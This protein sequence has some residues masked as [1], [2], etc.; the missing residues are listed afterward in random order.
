VL[1]IKRILSGAGSCP[2]LHRH[3]FHS[4]NN[5]K[6]KSV[7]YVMNRITSRDNL[8]LKHA[9]RVRDGMADDE[10]FIEGIRLVEE[11]LRSG[12][13]IND[14]FVSLELAAVERGMDLVDRLS[15][16]GISVSLVEHKLFQSLADTTNPQG[17]VL[18]CGRPD[19]SLSAFVERSCPGAI[20]LMVFLNEINNPSN[21]GAILRTAEAAGVSLV[22]ISKNSADAYSP[23]ALR[24]SMGASLR[25]NIWENA[26][27]NEAIGWAREKGVA[28]TAADVNAAK[29]YTEIDWT[30]PRL[31]VMG[32][33]AHGL[34]ASEISFIDEQIR[35]PMENNVESLNLAVSCGIIL[36]EAKRQTESS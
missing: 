33:E 30:I 16:Q 5:V 29:G 24:A 10:I 8:K 32:S 6:S 14:A 36:Y 13:Q 28:V 19:T 18:V 22:I 27:F 23:K 31:L 2:G 25:L 20:P 15:Q 7:D 9:K 21:L 1:D 34:S 26:A 35:I 11:A 4:A 3:F 12:A 17:I